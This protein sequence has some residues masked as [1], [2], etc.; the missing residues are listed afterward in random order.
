MYVP[1]NFEE[2]DGSQKEEEKE[3]EVNDQAVYVDDDFDSE[4]D[5]EDSDEDDED[6]MDDEEKFKDEELVDKSNNK[7]SEGDL[8]EISVND[9][10][11]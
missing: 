3:F 11:I 2:T 6:D 1:A 8:Q 9:K 10:S 7:N 5:D 4:E